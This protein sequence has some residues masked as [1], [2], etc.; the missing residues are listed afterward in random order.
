MLLGARRLVRATRDRRAE[1]QP[2]AAGRRPP[3]PARQR[4]RSGGAGSRGSRC[5]ARWRARRARALRSPSAPPRSSPQPRPRGT[6]R[7]CAASTC[8][9]TAPARRPR[10]RRRARDTHT[11]IQTRGTRAR[12]AARVARVRSRD[13]IPCVRHT[14]TAAPATRTNARAAGKE[15]T[16]EEHEH[17]ARPN[18]DSGQ[19]AATS[20]RETYRADSRRHVRLETSCDTMTSGTD[21]LR[22]ATAAS[23]SRRASSRH[24]AESEPD[25]AA[26]LVAAA[27]G[28]CAHVRTTVSGGNA[29]P[30]AA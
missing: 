9:R 30:S 6:R 25:A 15:E 4:G 19:R 21:A 26:T 24:A 28:S 11:H 13:N 23:A 27:A 14:T 8:G 1:Q 2:R 12:A 17:G 3:A 18:D 7:S 5:P 16:T 20:S 22:A 29:A 10:T